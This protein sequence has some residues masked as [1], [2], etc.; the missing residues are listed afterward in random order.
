MKYLFLFSFIILSQQTSAQELIANGDFE[1]ENICTEYKINCAPEGWMSTSN[2]F[3]N[4]FKEGHRAYS[5]THFM[6][7]EA[8]KTANRYKRTYLRT[9]LLCALRKG[10]KYRI[11]FYIRSVFQL[12][13]SVGLYFTEYDFLFEKKMPYTI[14]PHIFLRDQNQFRRDSNWQHVSIEYTADGTERY[15]TIGNFTKRDFNGPTNLEMES[16]FFIY[17]DAFS[18]RPVDPNEKL[19]SNWEQTREDVYGMNER[20]EYFERQLRF[21]RNNKKLPEQMPLGKTKMV[22]IDTLVLPDV[23]FATGRSALQ[24]TSSRVL[25]SFCVLVRGKQLD[26]IVVEGH[27]DTIGTNTNNEK[28][29]LD[30]ANM[31]SSYFKSTCLVP[32]NVIFSRGWASSRPVADN[33]TPS[34]RQKNRRV[35]VLLYVRE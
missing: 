35:E 33:R 17:V 15:M 10:N 32:G 11:E 6:G 3:S 2:G 34:G 23:L 12:L 31:V 22:I 21:Y 19:C 29:S 20:H 24:K 9:P 14:T 8:G 30:R 18:F 4:Y 13:D 16:R 28:L 27:T 25:D 7:I 1:E 5:G 26:S